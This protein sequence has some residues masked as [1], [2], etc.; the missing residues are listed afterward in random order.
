VGFRAEQL[1]RQAERET[2]K[3]R[4]RATRNA[5]SVDAA[6]RQSAQERLRVARKQAEAIRSRASEEAARAK[7]QASQE[8]VR[9][10]HV[11]RG[12]KEELGRLAEQLNAEMQRPDP[13]WTASMRSPGNNGVGRAGRQSV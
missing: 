2:A 13:G 6:A 7:A 3:M 12:M 5:E 9:V 10:R 11:H 8:A 4:T 1:L